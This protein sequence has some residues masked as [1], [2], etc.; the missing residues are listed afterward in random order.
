MKSEDIT[1][2]E[3]YN[4]DISKLKKEQEALREKTTFRYLGHGTKATGF[5]SKQF[6]RKPG[7]FLRCPEC[8]Y[9]MSLNTKGNETCICGSLIRTETDVKA[10]YG[11]NEV[12]VFVASR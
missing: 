4:R 7:Y 1:M 2:N 6:K 3:N 11:Q 8:N 10:A 12:E 9:Y 5:L